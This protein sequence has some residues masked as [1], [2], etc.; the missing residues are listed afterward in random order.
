MSHL[1]LFSGACLVQHWWEKPGFIRKQM[2]KKK[3]SSPCGLS[4][5]PSVETP[6][7]PTP[8]TDPKHRVVREE[9]DVCHCSRAP[10]PG[11]GVQPICLHWQ[12]AVVYSCRTIFHE[13]RG[14][15]RLLMNI[16]LLRNVS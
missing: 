3:P 5:C 14:A 8:R 15:P 10:A 12:A 9:I 6:T 2:A 13:D 1:S 16:T 4:S 7:A 11:T